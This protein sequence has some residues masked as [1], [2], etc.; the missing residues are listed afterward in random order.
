MF[1]LLYIF[2][3][4]AVLALRFALGAIFLVHGASKAKNLQG[5]I[6]WFE[7]VGFRPG[8][9]WAPLVTFVELV[10][11]LLIAVGLWTQFVA[12]VFMLQFLVITVWK[13][14]R[15]EAFVGNLEF[16]LIIWTAAFLLVTLGGGAFSL[17][18]ISSFL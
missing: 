11:G 1:P 10:G 14:G 12:F 17:D 5:T 4:W 16:D 6:G 18:A 15:R 9:F 8:A 2:W 3:D 13:I 7:S